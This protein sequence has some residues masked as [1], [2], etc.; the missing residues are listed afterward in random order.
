MDHRWGH[1]SRADLPVQ[2]RVSSRI[3]A[4]GRLCDI[5]ISG[6]FIRSATVPALMTRIRLIGISRPGAQSEPL[7]LEGFVVRRAVDGFGIEWVELTSG[8]G[9]EVTAAP[10]VRR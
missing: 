8:A 7:E 4:T 9:P 1:R 6:G 10:T 3:L 2:L 5:S